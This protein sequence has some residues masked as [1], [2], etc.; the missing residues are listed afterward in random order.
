MLNLPSWLDF[1]SPCSMEVSLQTST[2]WGIAD[3]GNLEGVF[4]LLV[5][6]GILDKF[7]DEVF[8]W[9]TRFRP[10]RP[11]VFIVTSLSPA[12]TFSA[13]TELSLSW[14]RLPQAS[15]TITFPSF[16]ASSDLSI[17]LVLRRVNRT[18]SEKFVFIVLGGTG[19]LKVL[20]STGVR[21][22]F[23]PV[24]DESNGP[25]FTVRTFCFL[26]SCSESSVDCLFGA[27]LVKALTCPSGESVFLAFFLLDNASLD[28]GDR[29]VRGWVDLF[30]EAFDVLMVATTCL[31]TNNSDPYPSSSPLLSDFLS[32]ATLVGFSI[33]FWLLTGG[34]VLDS[35]SEPAFWFIFVFWVGL[36][37]RLDGLAMEVVFRSFLHSMQPF[38]STAVVFA[39]NTLTLSPLVF[40][41]N[42]EIEGKSVTG[43]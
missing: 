38:I 31:G 2:G 4:P 10:L 3:V 41:I 19:G 39:S 22:V 14:E 18:S 32:V 29:S 13:L 23:K 8:V 11:L 21:L 34:V 7:D 33:S 1:V 27:T 15:N 20:P 25:G 36:P 37:T 30:C 5:W 28:F 26:L 35:C 40:A 9:V 6:C 24:S 16:G 17:L 43:V 42:S 12:T